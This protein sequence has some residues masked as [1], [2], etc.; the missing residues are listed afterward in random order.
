MVL[1]SL[2]NFISDRHSVTF[3]YCSIIYKKLSTLLF[4]RCLLYATYDKLISSIYI[5]I[6]ISC[7]K[8][9]R[10]YSLCILKKPWFY[11]HFSNFH[12]FGIS[13]TLMHTQPHDEFPWVVSKKPLNSEDFNTKSNSTLQE[14]F[15]FGNLFKPHTSVVLNLSPIIE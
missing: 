8:I 10:K 7:Q 5:F 13:L 9:G 2:P 4:R 14:P 6:Y 12:F 11:I 15:S 1:L 3:T